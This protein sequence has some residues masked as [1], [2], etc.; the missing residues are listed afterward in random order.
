MANVEEGSHVPSKLAVTDTMLKVS[1]DPRPVASRPF[2]SCL[3]DP[4]PFDPHLGVLHSSDPRLVDPHTVGRYSVGSHSFV[5][6]SVDPCCIFEP[7]RATNLRAEAAADA[8]RFQF[9]CG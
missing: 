1:L 9:R 8:S 2:V 4:R 3:V 7:K 6:P 5:S